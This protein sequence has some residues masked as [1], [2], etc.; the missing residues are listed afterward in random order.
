MIPTFVQSHAVKSISLIQLGE[1]MDYDSSLAHRHDYFELFI[2]RKGGGTHTI[3]FE[4][5]TILD[6]SV[7]IVAPGR[8][9]QMNRD[10]HSEGY[11]CLF[12]PDVTSGIPFL[13]DFLF[14]QTCFSVLEFPPAFNMLGND[15]VRLEQLT[16]QFSEEYLSDNAWKNESV[17]HYLAL[18]GVLCVRSRPSFKPLVA[19]PTGTV[20][21]D[22]RKMLH[23]DF[24]TKKRVK[25]YAEQLHVTEKQLNEIVRKQTGNS[26][27][28][29]IYTR[30]ITEARR[31]LNTGISVKE[32]AFAL[33][34]DDPAH[35]SK[36]FRTQTGISP[37]DFRNV[38]D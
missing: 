27:S 13:N 35:F 21:R 26:V 34:F 17:L 3:D 12:E 1:R 20:Y 14:D 28:A 11:V 23:T 38:H 31:L 30:I 37:S 8:V 33:Q 25:D 22:F 18:I 15:Q 4:P 7:H 9:H 5:F 6:Y 10:R 24:L 36:F 32:T 29:M 16:T 19:G 2:F